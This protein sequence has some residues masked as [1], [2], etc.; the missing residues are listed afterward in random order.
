MTH[1][2]LHLVGTWRR[3]W[4]LKLSW[5]FH[6]WFSQYCRCLDD[7]PFLLQLYSCYCC[8]SRTCE[9]EEQDVWTRSIFCVATLNE[10]YCHPS[11]YSI[12]KSS[13]GYETVSHKIHLYIFVLVP[14]Y[15][16]RL[17]WEVVFNGVWVWW[18]M[19]KN[20]VENNVR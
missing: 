16:D 10:T 3:C 19:P 20:K 1:F 11:L 12:S 4:Y 8:Y 6:A 18:S 15:S 2:S 14:H 17:T 9:C 13:R 7:Y 5:L